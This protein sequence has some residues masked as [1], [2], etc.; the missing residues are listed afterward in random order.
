MFLEIPTAAMAHPTL[1]VTLRCLTLLCILSIAMGA[2]NNSTVSGPIH[3][4]CGASS[5][6]ATDADNRTWHSDNSSNFAPSLKGV[7]ATA[8]YQDPALPSTVPYMTARIFTSNYTYSFPVSPGRLFVRLYFYPSTYGNYAPANA[9]FGVTASNL[10]LLDN[11][12]ASQTALAANIASFVREYSVNVTSGNL[13][14]T[15]SPSTQQNGSY[16]FVNGIEI[17]PTPDLFT[18]PTP[19]LTN[20]GNP[21]PFPINPTTGF[22]TMHRLNVG[23]QFI[24]PQG[25]VDFYRSWD[26][27]T[28]YINDAGY[29][30]AFGK[31]RNVTI[32]YT[33][34]VPNYTAPVDVYATA[35]SMGP[36]A[37]INLNSNLTWTLPVDAGF[38]Y[39]L[40]FHF[41]E[42]QYPIT[43]VNQ[44]SF[45]IYINN[46]TAQR[47]MD[48]IAWSNGIGRTVYMDYAILT[49]G[50]GQMDLWVALHPD[51]STRPEYYDAILNG[52]EVFK[53]QNYGNNSLAGLNPPL[54]QSP[55]EPNGTPGGG[56]SKGSA[57]PAIGG[58]V[59]GFAVLLIAC[60]GV[61][62]ICRRKK[63]VAKESDKSDDGR[64]TPL[65]DY[66]KSQSNTSG[67]TATSRSHTSTLPSN[68]CR[69]FSFGEIQA[70][71]NNFDQAFLLG[72]G[73]FGNVY[74]GEIDS[75][76]K[77]AIKRG[78]PMSEQGV[79]EFQ[80]EIE[81]LSKLRHRHL[82]S[83]IGYCEDM[84][85]MILV[86]DYMA[87]GTLRE[88]L[89]N[90]KNPPLSWK[91]RLGI[92]IG[93]AQGL[94]Y[95][96]TG[97]KQT[98]IHRDVKTTNILLDEKW[99]AKVSDFGL[100]KTGPNVDNTHVSTVV[101]G[102]FGYL[103]PEYFRRQ[104][105][106]EKSDVYSF[107]VVLFEVLSARPAL[108]P[109]L[110]KEQVSLADWALHCQKK[111]M[112]G[113]IIDPYLQGKIAPQCFMKFA[114]TAVK[115]VADH[116][117]DRPSMGDVLW[118][119]EFALQLQESAENSSSLTEGTSSNTS[120]LTVPSIHSDEPLTDTITTTSTTMSIA[121]RSITSTESDG[122]TPS[123]VF[124]Q[125]MN[126]GGR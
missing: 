73:G 69:H 113:Q 116:S 5:P 57:A 37:Q 50:S 49:I 82:V 52:L 60:I 112:L 46:Q 15:F 38:Y 45:F 105:L 101:K 122:L 18:T 61:C 95:L 89:Y 77:V 30:V 42:I 117:I 111:G 114:E 11:F 66:S 85:E 41:C 121:G 62:I 78:N 7:A 56:N 34:S 59:G 29:G 115:C 8:S 68:L 32:T 33:P 47:Q 28:P 43:K 27:D 40:R 74:L 21:D 76:T 67:K 107:G 100:S 123:S 80:T 65:T 91:Q 19:T 14:V 64:W 110:P 4:D 93:A 94:H 13:D 55:V 75:G 72:K 102:S 87:H 10:V 84:N 103:D 98:I 23:G 90:T 71:T 1:L 96:H 81:M 108:S 106:T 17:V 6:T 125:L 83:L 118:N 2:D 36:N 99:I 51:L 26:D 20:G 120:P 44:R 70:A 104:Q 16:A 79:H 53:L 86:Y 39:L 88:H 24:S 97:A 25:D 109:S 58:A 63:K 22:Q 124:S 92:C 35:R 126:P 54:L 119:L 9:Y 12:N 31:D 3:L 48:V